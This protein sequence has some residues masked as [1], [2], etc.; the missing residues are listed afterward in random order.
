MNTTKFF[1]KFIILSSVILALFSCKK[2][3]TPSVVNTTPKTSLDSIAEEYYEGYLQFH[4][5]E[6]TAQGDPRYN[7]KLPS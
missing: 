5:L 1:L 3:D 7:D 2:G 4:P 6:A